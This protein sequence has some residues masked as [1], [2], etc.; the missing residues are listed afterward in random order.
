MIDLYKVREPEDFYNLL[1]QELFTKTNSK[2]DD[3]IASTRKFFKSIIPKIS[4]NP[5]PDSEISFGFEW[6]DI[7][8]NQDELLNM[9]EEIAKS[10][11]IQ[12]VLCID[13]FQNIATFEEP[14]GF[15][16]KLRANWQH[17]EHV[18]YCLYGSKRHMMMEVFSSR[19]MPFY[20]FGDLM[21]LEKISEEEW[22][23]FIMRNF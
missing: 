3:I 16:K 19:A 17:H 2:A 8:K 20:K 5:L 9:A 12:I 14:I 22:V 1:I 11:G 15:Q 18:T 7:K 21:F 13:E 6:S 4:Y 23:P 10:K